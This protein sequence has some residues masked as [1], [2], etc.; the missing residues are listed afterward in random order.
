MICDHLAS[1]LNS[2]T[3]FIYIW[4]WIYRCNNI[5]FFSKLFKFTIDTFTVYRSIVQRPVYKIK[6]V[7]RSLINIYTINVHF[8]CTSY[9]ILYLVRNILFNF[10]SWPTG[11]NLI[12]WSMKHENLRPTNGCRHFDFMW[13]IRRR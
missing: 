9:I 1:L 5:I 2:R 12:L 10:I 6:G 13:R 11:E 7:Y 8:R 3:K 4:R